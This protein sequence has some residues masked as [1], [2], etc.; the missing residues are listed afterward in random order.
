MSYWFMSR[1]YKEYSKVTQVNLLCSIGKEKSLP[2]LT[3]QY[4]YLLSGTETT[5]LFARGF[6][7]EIFFCDVI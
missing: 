4:L 5:L 3:S 1:E 2:H 7:P 6:L